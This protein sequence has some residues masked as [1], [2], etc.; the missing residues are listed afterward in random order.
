MHSFL[1]YELFPII[2]LVIIV[3]LAYVIRVKPNLRIGVSLLLV[4]FVVVIVGIIKGSV[5]RNI[6]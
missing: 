3:V 5:I 2:L 6:L 4:S 1:I